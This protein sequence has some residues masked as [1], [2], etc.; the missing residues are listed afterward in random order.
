MSDGSSVKRSTRVVR[1]GSVKELSEKFIQ[2]ESQYEHEQPSASTTTNYTTK[3]TTSSNTYP[4]SKYT[5]RTQMQS[6]RASTPGNN[7]IT[8]KKNALINKYINFNPI[9]CPYRFNKFTL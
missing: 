8:I 6:S 3:T 7:C 1:R 4:K 9:N 5:I 2:S